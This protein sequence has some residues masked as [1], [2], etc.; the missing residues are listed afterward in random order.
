MSKSGRLSM[1]AQLEVP[2]GTKAAPDLQG[3]SL[4]D[5]SPLGREDH[6]AVAPCTLAEP[7]PAGGSKE[8]SLRH[9]S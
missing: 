8:T 1:V 6:S 5:E 2:L 4:V 9:N 3:S 7:C